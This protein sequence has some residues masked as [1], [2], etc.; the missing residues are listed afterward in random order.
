MR[1]EALKARLAVVAHPNGAR[2]VQ[3]QEI[4]VCAPLREVD[5]VDRLRA[6]ALE[7]KAAAMDAVV[8][9]IFRMRDLSVE[10]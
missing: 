8:D 10:N 4:A 1:T 6:A 3:R 9:E 5:A 7:A 2:L